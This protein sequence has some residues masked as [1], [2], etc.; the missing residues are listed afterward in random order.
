MDNVSKWVIGIT[1]GILLALAGWPAVIQDMRGMYASEGTFEGYREC[2]TDGPDS[3]AWIASRD[4]S[5]G[6]VSTVGP[7]ALGICQYFMAG[8]NPPELACQGE[9]LS[10]LPCFFHC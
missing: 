6:K 5:N 7:S 3:L 10:V 9:S 1:L 4:W 8:A 2:Q